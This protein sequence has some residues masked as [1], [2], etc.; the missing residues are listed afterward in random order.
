MVSKPTKRTRRPESRPDEILDAALAVFTEKGFA[1][2]RVEDVAKQAGLSKGAIYLYFPSKEAMLNALVEQSA[3][4]LAK[5]GEQLVASGAAADPEAAYRAVLTMILTAMSDPDISAAP[6]LVLAE[7]QRFPDLAAY[8]R[9]N[10]IDTGR[11]TMRTLLEAGI[12]KGVFRNVDPEAAMRSFAGPAIAH[13]LLTTV[14]LAPGDPHHDPAKLA[15]DIA[16]IVLN[17]LKR[18]PGD[19]S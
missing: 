10:V 2:A 3:G 13:M 19:P 8:Y 14:F 16:D 17:G 9:S 6:R 12:A 4:A 15:N 11:R 18:H 1:S 5:A 7:A